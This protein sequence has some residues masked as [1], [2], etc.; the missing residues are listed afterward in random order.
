MNLYDSI[1]RVLIRQMRKVLPGK[2][3][4]PPS[5]SKRN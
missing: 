1:W 2:L 5:A 4:Y 3:P